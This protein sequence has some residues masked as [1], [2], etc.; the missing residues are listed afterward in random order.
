MRIAKRVGT[1]ALLVVV[2]AAFIGPFLLL[3][4]TALKPG[5][6]SVFSFPPDLIPRP[7]VVDWFIEA[8]TTIPYGKFV[9]NSLFYVGVMVPLYL[10]VSAMTAYPLARIAFRGRQVFF[11]LFLS[12]MFLPGEL[13][14]IPRFLVMRELGLIDTYAAVILP[15]ILSALGIFMLRQTF[16]TIP[17]AIIEAA[18]VDGASEWRIFLSIALPLARPTL[19]VLTILGFISVWNSFLWPLVALTDQSKFPL[20]LG[21]AYLSGVSGADVRGL[22]AGTVLSLIP[23]V[24]VFL[25]LQRHI[26]S[27]MAGA[28][29]G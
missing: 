11:L 5:S 19:A 15:G 20:A 21:I 1:Y 6:Q 28:I 24:A 9:L 26:L 14:L 13:M 12:T 7:P 16:A 3:L 8:W 4:S 17:E 25:F 27:S 18:R 23:V 10:V 22:A 2:A 29:K